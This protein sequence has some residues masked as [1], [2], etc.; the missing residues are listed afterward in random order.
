MF[1][2]GQYQKTDLLLNY[3]HM[4]AYFST[5]HGS[6]QDRGDDGEITLRG[7]VLPVGGIKE[8]VLAAHR[9]GIK[10]LI[11]PEENT[12]DLEE[13][14]QKVKD[15]L[16]F[17]FVNTMDEV[18]EKAIKPIPEKPVNLEKMIPNISISTHRSYVRERFKTAPL[19][20]TS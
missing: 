13:V 11:L 19:K 9:A 16:C 8:K 2:K 14:P 15:D 3:N 20:L 18:I 6:G 7:R 12:K 5:Q 4:C 10:T 1:L 17:I